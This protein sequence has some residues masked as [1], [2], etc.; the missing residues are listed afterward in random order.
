MFLVM[1]NLRMGNT[2]GTNPRHD[3]KAASSP[4]TVGEGVVPEY[5]LQPAC[6][7][8]HL[9]C[10]STAL[11]RTAAHL[12]ARDLLSQEA[13]DEDVVKGRGAEQEG[14]GGEGEADLG[15]GEGH[16]GFLLRG[17]SD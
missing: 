1:V 11:I 8:A 16:L 7:L 2:R 13:R 3:Q 14:V 12:E 10:T 4:R 9:Q 15:Q 17:A 6:Q 5:A